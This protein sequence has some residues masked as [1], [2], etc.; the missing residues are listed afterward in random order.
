MSQVVH[1]SL[2]YLTDSDLHAIAAYLKTVP[3]IA[4]Y[5]AERPSA[6]SGAHPAG[7]DAY[8]DRCASCH[9]VNGK[10]LPGAVPALDGNSLVQARGP[11]D[12]IRV[13]LGGRLATGTFAPMPAVGAD[14]TDQEIAD[15]TDYVRNAWSNS[16]PVIEKTSLVGQIRA[17]TLSTLAGPG[18]APDDGRD[19]CAIGEDF[20]AVPPIDDA[21]IDQTLAAM[22]PESML[23]A[24]PTLVARVREI[25]PGKP[26]ADI[27]N[28]LMLAYCR[29]ESRMASF[30]KPHGRDLLNRFGQLVYSEVASNGQE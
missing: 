29:I 27:V 8:L 1:D 16:A 21:K 20:P 10:G 7:A 19:P 24:I 30:R 6:E 14:M 26:Q 28:G 25:S 5:R 13:I 12:V 23:S 4:D 17:R 15:V 9:Q 22:N 11:E 3:P 2:A 18:G